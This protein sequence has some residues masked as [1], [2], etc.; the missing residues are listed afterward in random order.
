MEGRALQRRNPLPNLQHHSDKGYQYT[1]T[2]F[3]TLL[4]EYF[5]IY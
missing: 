2:T 5:W 1:S 3:Q 4:A